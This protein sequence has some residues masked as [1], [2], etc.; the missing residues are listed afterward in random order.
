MNTFSFRND[1]KITSKELTEELASCDW[2]PFGPDE[3]DLEAW[4]ACLSEFLLATINTRKASM[5]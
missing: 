1:R 4:L 5:D 2:L 3:L